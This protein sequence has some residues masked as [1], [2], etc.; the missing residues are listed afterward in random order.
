MIA[1]GVLVTTNSFHES[2]RSRASAETISLLSSAA[3]ELLAL[4]RPNAT[5]SKASVGI[6]QGHVGPGKGGQEDGKHRTSKWRRVA[7]QA[8]KEFELLDRD[9]AVVEQGES[10]DQLRF[11]TMKV[12]LRC[13]FFPLQPLDVFQLVLAHKVR[14]SYSAVNT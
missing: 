7:E 9:D 6:E 1:Q 13:L 4:R 5:A 12:D 10:A 3:H 11:S 14:G 8:A 2:W